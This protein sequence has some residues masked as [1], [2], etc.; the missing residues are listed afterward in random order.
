MRLSTGVYLSAPL[1][2]KSN[3]TLDIGAGVR[4]LASS[5]AADYSSSA[6]A[7]LLPL[8]GASQQTDI[9]ITGQ[10]TIDG[11]GAPWWAAV[12]A[13]RQAGQPDPARPH[14][15]DFVS[16]QRVNVQGVTLANSPGAHLV[17]TGSDTV[18]ISGVTIQAPPD[19]PDTDGIDPSNSRNVTISNCAIDTGGDNIAIQS[20][21]VDPNH[22]GAGSENISIA[23]CAF[24]HGRGLSIGSA[25]IG[26]VRSVQ[27]Q[28]C[29]GTDNGLRIQSDR[30]E[31]GE[32]SQ[33]S[34]SDITMD[35]VGAAIVFTGYYPTIPDTDSPQPV[36]AL[37][38]FY[39]DIKITNLNAT[40]GSSSGVIVG[41]P[42]TPLSGI[43]F[44][45]V[46]IS[47]DSA[48]VV[49]N[50]SVLTTSTTVPFILQGGALVGVYF[51]PAGI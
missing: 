37:T 1:T 51:D 31:G 15:I 4:L 14:L 19:S 36:T 2:L 3:V 22:P 30:G 24:L 35:S 33:I 10:G 41:L 43:I 42:E 13:A 47:A 50:A 28:R 9:A 39:H 34:Y 49:R 5:D 7:P 18:V 46:N 23:D 8:V 16:C 11:A 12:L 29:K 6:G 48:L 38:P 44:N 40:G 26:G 17:P 45:Q 25:T 20:A 32:V 27:V 21:T